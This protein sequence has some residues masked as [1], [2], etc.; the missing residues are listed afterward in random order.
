MKSDYGLIK[1]FGPSIFK[2]KIPDELVGNLNNF[3]DNTIKDEEQFKKLDVGKTLVGD[4]KQEFRLHK[5]I[6]EESGWLKFLGDSIATWIY[7]DMGEK[8]SEF[9]LIE[10]WVVRQFQNEYNPI[11]WH[12]GHVSGAGFL[13]VPKTFGKH[14][15]ENKINYRGGN[16]DLIH[17]NRMFL[18]PSRYP[19]E[20]KVGDFYFF[21]HYL[22]HTVYP[23]KGTNEERRSI[24]FNG[25]IDN[26]IF[27]IF[28]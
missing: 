27:N 21:P 28:G 7:R 13:K 19:I 22:M 2:A 14:Y 10:T 9:K 25:L 6:V 3:I 1:P 11:H 18:S 5:K 8:I 24:S 23:F 20:P 15:Q 12:S 26:K 16:L 17:G 4:V